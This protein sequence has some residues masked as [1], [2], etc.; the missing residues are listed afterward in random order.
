MNS[1]TVRTKKKQLPPWVHDYAPYIVLGVVIVL[2]VIPVHVFRWFDDPVVPQAVPHAELAIVMGPIRTW[3]D[4]SNSRLKSVEVKVINKGAV[5]A[6]GVMVMA[7]SKG[8]SFQ[9]VGKPRLVVG[10]T[11]GYSADV[12]D[13]ITPEDVIEFS[14]ECSTC[15]P[16]A[17]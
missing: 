3:R 14:L 7:F 17:R 2:Y 13:V 6:D 5:P 10:E 12:P 16:F 4:G 9:L 8:E 1:Y 15:S 11:Q